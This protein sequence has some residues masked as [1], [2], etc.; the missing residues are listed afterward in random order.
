MTP[1]PP[2]PADLLY[3][4]GRR[5]LQAEDRRRARALWV[6][7][8]ALNP[9]HVRSWTAL[10]Q[11]CADP[12]EQLY[13]LY[14]LGRL[15]PQD[16]R[17]RRAYER[18]RAQHPSARPRPLPELTA[19]PAA[20]PRPET[21]LAAMPDQPLAEAPSPAA[22][23][24]PA[25]STAQSRTHDAVAARRAEQ[26]TAGL[27]L[28]AARKR[29]AGDDTG[30]LAV[31]R[32]ILRSDPTHVEALAES[33]RILSRQKRLEEARDWVEHSLRA[34]N[35]DPGAYVSLAELRLL[36]GGGDP[37][38]PLAALRRLPDLKPHHLLG[39]ASVYWRHGQLRPALETLHA[40]EQMAPHE[41]AVLMRL[42]QAYEELGS[43]KRVVDRGARTAIGQAAEELLLERAPHIPRHIQM[44]MLYALREVLGIFLLFL[45]IAI[46]DAGV[47]LTGISLAGWAGLL[48]SLV[49]GY[50]VVSAASSP[51]QQVFQRFLRPSA[52]PEK[53]SAPDDPYLPE[54][55]EDE[56]VPSLPMEVRLTLGTVGGVLLIVAAVL[57]L[58]N[59][60]LSAQQ[61]LST[62][63][64]GQLPGYL[65]DIFDRLMAGVP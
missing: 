57:V 41:Q 2:S 13:C 9:R 16:P 1:P 18:F 30:A 56:P 21:A 8:V 37:W 4:A 32:D 38:E 44:H 52:A 45:L 17:L 31:Y 24:R 47:S 5:A 50:L 53:R 51:S 39:A 36:I 48:L 54:T 43:L 35:R 64:S 49:G 63:N 23:A 29:E 11:V 22:P 59:S 19:P 6:Q 3:E 62:L 7:A 33:V 26:L 12:D 28:V 58:R 65:L 27:L 60:L 20:D 42:A 10:L 46:L 55:L 34:G 40:A 14:Q 25:E 61:T 15:N